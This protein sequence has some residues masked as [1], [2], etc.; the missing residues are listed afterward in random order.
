MNFAPH[1][2]ATLLVFEAKFHG[3]EFRGSRRLWGLV[4][5]VGTQVLHHCLKV[6]RHRPLMTK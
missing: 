2:R 3:R 5:T 1:D 6:I 4:R